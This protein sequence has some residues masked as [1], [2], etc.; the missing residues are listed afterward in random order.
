MTHILVLFKV[1]TL[2]SFLAFVSHITESPSRMCR[3]YYVWPGRYL[4]DMEGVCYK[5]QS[6]RKKVNVI[7]SSIVNARHIMIMNVLKPRHWK[8]GAPHLYGLRFPALY[9]HL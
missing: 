1:Q 6:I 8:A 3:I 7:L 9:K 2:L 4:Q 5:E